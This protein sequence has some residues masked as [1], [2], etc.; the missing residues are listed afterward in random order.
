MGP[1]T[2]ILSLLDDVNYTAPGY[3]LA[4]PAVA[5][6]TLLDAITTAPPAVSVAA[7]TPEISE[8]GVDTGEFV[9]T[10]TGSE[11]GNLVVN[12]SLGGTAQAGT[13]FS[14]LAGVVIIPAGQASAVVSVQPYNNYALK[15]PVTLVATVQG[16]AAYT[17]G[18]AAS[19]TITLL[20]DDI[21]TVTVYPTA[22][23]TSPA[24]AGVFTIQRDGDLTSALVVNYNV[25]GTAVPGVQY[26]A[27]S[28]TATIPAGAAS[29]PV[30]V[31]VL[32]NSLSDQ[33]VTLVL[34][35]DFNY[36]VGN[37]GAATIWITDGA[38]PTVS[39]RATVPEVSEQGNTFGEFQISRTGTAGA[40]T[41]N[42]A[43]SGTAMPG[44]NYL[45]LDTPVVIPDG[46]SSVML[47]VIP[48]QDAILD[49]T[50]TVELTLLASTNYNIAQPATATVLIDDDGTSQTPGVGFCFGSSQYPASLSPGIAVGLTV[51]SAVPV[52]VDY[53]VI[54]GT[55]PSSLYS[56]PQGTLQISN[57]QVAFVPL[58]IND[59][60]GIPLPKTISVVLFNPTNATLGAIRVHTYTVLN[61]AAAAVSVAA[62][63]PAAS[64]NGPVPGNF[65]ISRAGPTNASQAVTFQ[66]TGTAS[67]PTDYQ[68]LGNSATIPAGAA[69]VD[70]PVIPTGNSQLQ[71]PQTVVLTLISA[72]NGTIVSPAAATVS[73]SETNTNPLPLVTVSSTNQ[74]YAVA[75]GVNGAFVF[76]RT[77]STANPLTLTLS[78]GGTAAP[79]R[80]SPLPNSITIPAGQLS[81]TLPVVAL[82]DGLV[83]GDQTVTVTLTANNAYQIAYPSAAAVTVQDADQKVW[84]DAS[85]FDASKYGPIP[86]QFTCSRFGTTNS[87]VTV[88]Y[89][90]SGTASNGWDY[91]QITNS[92]VIPA[93]QLTATLAIL[94]QHTG[95]PVGPLTA[96]LTLRAGTN[97]VLGTPGSGT[98]TI[99][100][101][102][103]MVTITAITPTVLEGSATNGD[104]RLVRAGNPQFDFTADLAVGGTAVYNVDYAGFITNVYFSCGVTAIDLT[105]PTFNNALA[106]GDHTV[107]AALIPDPAAYTVL[108][109]SNAVIGITD[110]GADQTP[111]V[112]ITKPSEKLVYLLQ[113]NRGILL[114]ATVVTSG[115]NELSWTELN[116]NTN[117]IFDSTNTA[118]TGVLFAQ[119][120]VYQLQLTAD[121]GILQ[122]SDSITV[123]TGPGSVTPPAA[124]YWPFDEGTGTVAHDVSGGGHDGILV[125]NPVWVTN[126]VIGDA[127]SFSGTNDYVRQ[128]A[129]GN[130][131]NGQNAF[132]LS[133]WLFTTSTNMDQG[134]FTASLS[135]G[136]TVSLATRSHATCGD[137]TNVFEATLATTKGSA[138][139]ISANNAVMTN[140]WQNVILTWS[141]GLPPQLYL[142]G[143]Q[144]QPNSQFIAAMGTL[145]NCPDFAVGLGPD[146]SPAS[147]NGLID[148]V[149]FF[150]ELLDTNEILTIGAMAPANSTN[151]AAPLV[152]VEPD[153]TVQTG[154]PFVLYGSA[155]DDGLPNPPGQLTTTWQQLFTNTVTIPD[156]NAL[157]NT[158]VFAN[159][160]T[161][162]FRLTADDSDIAVFADVTI[163][164]IPP[165]E[166]DVNADVADA[167]DMGPV[168]GDLTFTRNGDTNTLTV[169]FTVTGSAS[170]GV[171]YVLVTNQLTF[172]VGSNSISL[173]VLPILSYAIKGDRTVVVT[174]ITNMAYSIGSGQATVTIHDSPYGVWSIGYF[175]IRELTEPQL[176][177]AGGDF[178]GDGIPNFVKYAFNLDP[179][180]FNP[181]P[182]FQWDF[183]I[184][185]NS[186]LHYLTLTYTRWLPPRVVQYGVYVSPDLI[187]W[188]TGSN[189][190]SEFS[191]LPDTN[192]ITE[193]VKTRALTPY[194]GTSN[195]FMTIRVWLT[196]VPD[197]P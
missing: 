145:T 70:L 181:P 40:L 142:N 53:K 197:G 172:P 32:T 147:W 135:G 165:T 108:S 139:R 100:D 126:G 57:V 13:D 69:Y 28:G 99:D 159:P 107:T 50:N 166:V 161:D 86:G 101:D 78:V 127:L 185:T 104:L 168:P 191:N 193:T 182:P 17:T 18:S 19:A 95:I 115:T 66:V 178:S 137:F 179:L 144:D 62:T 23:P 16:S 122:G 73:I 184:D 129:G 143:L 149:M 121:D 39:I 85:I 188:Y 1:Q 196:Q 111:L 120:G 157:T 65:R 14:P 80:F 24:S 146:D 92:M 87:A 26:A 128:N 186:Q 141:N 155:T 132:T 103:P 64:E 77:G 177:G 29:V 163:T 125:G 176:S 171:E 21:T 35:N 118:D 48:F 113:T 116:G 3:A 109:P 96:T 170:N 61:D 2:V 83:S 60:A 4:P 72:T 148:E 84:I 173:P 42:V 156:T 158:I 51:T 194:P 154:V 195:L 31:R 192:G 123:I 117:A 167:Y 105:F 71:L 152:S 45:P 74:A 131:L 160:E 94:P 25:A 8:D 75:G 67:A 63:V 90:V 183:E 33:S 175:G 46:A 68:P 27:L 59:H 91:A 20:N 56:L 55:A 34:T 134:F 79:T 7:A 88:Y 47:D 153:A 9:F 133:L 119:P 124:L 22:E 12:Y 41:V 5:T 138:S 114:Q 44:W 6:I 11:Q 140:Q 82:D 97:Y 130:L 15:A 110:A 93:G 98:V 190:V 36:Q 37:L 10:R 136:A 49:P 43:V 30:T 189:Y 106:D 169:Y 174:L 58:Q 187:N 89:T 162:V 52:T 54:G 112:Q 180:T 164:V 81:V 150:P 151:N 76:T 102:M 38:L